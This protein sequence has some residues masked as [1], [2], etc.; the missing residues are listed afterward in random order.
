MI[1]TRGKEVWYNGRYY[2]V[3]HVHVQGYYLLVYLDGIAT[4]IPS[5]QVF[6]E[7][8]VIDKERIL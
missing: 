5:E 6:C 7:P 3:D 8:T 2:N 1:Y 4:G